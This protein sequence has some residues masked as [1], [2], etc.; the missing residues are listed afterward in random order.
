[1]GCETAGTPQKQ[2]VSLD[3][4]G[5]DYWD[6]AR[7]A[8]AR[9]A[10]DGLEFTQF[11]YLLGSREKIRNA[12]DVITARGVLILGRFGGGGLEVLQSGGA[13][14]RGEGYLP[15]L[16]DFE[17]PAGSG[18]VRWQCVCGAFPFSEGR[19]YLFF[20]ER[21]AKS[22]DS[23]VLC[24]GTKRASEAAGRRF[25]PIEPQIAQNCQLHRRFCVIYRAFKMKQRHPCRCTS[26][27]MS[28]L[29]GLPLE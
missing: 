21:L 1:M 17:R 20:A 13:T 18:V 9:I 11:I 15:I 7:I 2:L 24:G 19:I 5:Q 16:F 28:N 10:V 29:Q 6:L 12:I 23:V 26:Q 3:A 27:R 8:E 22:S 14:L 4:P 25:F